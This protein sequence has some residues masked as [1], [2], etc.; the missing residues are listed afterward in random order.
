MKSF[1]EA[2][3]YLGKDNL[4][5]FKLILVSE[6]TKINSKT[7]LGFDQISVGPSG[8]QGPE[9]CRPEIFYLVLVI[10]EGLQSLY[11]LINK[12][13]NISYTAK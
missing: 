11:C 4:C 13:I 2:F 1:F 7:K 8:R 3:K 10:S 5:I 9:F 6:N 12:R